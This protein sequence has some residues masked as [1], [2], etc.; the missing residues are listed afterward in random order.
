MKERKETGG[1][2]T[3]CSTER[4]GDIKVEGNTP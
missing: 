3:E 2:R 4:G 1:G